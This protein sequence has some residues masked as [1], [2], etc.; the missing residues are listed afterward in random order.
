MICEHFRVMHM[1]VDQ[2]KS[3]MFEQLCCSVVSPQIVFGGQMCKLHHGRDT[4][5]RSSTYVLTYRL[6]TY[7][8]FRYSIVILCCFID[9]M[10]YSHNFTLLF[11]IMC[12]LACSKIGVR[13]KQSGLGPS[14]CPRL[15]STMKTVSPATKSF[16]GHGQAESQSKRLL[17]WSHSS[18]HFA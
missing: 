17:L 15:M 16:K 2:P 11:I 10:S 6:R 12:L 4:N 1:N 14:P 13:K 3:N 8:C 5:M 7:F 9:C 18:S